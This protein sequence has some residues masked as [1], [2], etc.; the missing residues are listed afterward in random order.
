MRKRVKDSPDKPDWVEYNRLNEN[1]A[2]VQYSL[3]EQKN[4]VDLEIHERA[5][6]T[7]YVKFRGREFEVGYGVTKEYEN[8]LFNGMPR[9]LFYKKVTLPGSRP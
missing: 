5:D 8:C 6:K 3:A 9:R 2:N 1:Y 4:W 7:Q